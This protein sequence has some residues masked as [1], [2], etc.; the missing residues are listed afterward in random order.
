MFYPDSSIVFFP[1]GFARTSEPKSSSYAESN[2]QPQKIRHA[3]RYNASEPVQNTPKSLKEYRQLHRRVRHRLQN[4][5]LEI[6]NSS[7]RPPTMRS[8]TRSHCPHR[9]LPKAPL[10]LQIKA[11]NWPPANK[12]DTCNDD[13][14]KTITEV[15][16][17]NMM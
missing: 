8:T 1:N 14:L 10:P 17:G 9:G 16:A 13:L 12:I 15:I 5:H 7:P 11:T 4:H 2:D 3:A 6:L